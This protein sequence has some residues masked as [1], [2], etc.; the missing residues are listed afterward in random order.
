M[1]GPV[2][3]DLLTPR[4]SAAF[5]LARDLSERLDSGMQRHL[6]RLAIRAQPDLVITVDRR[7]RPDTVRALRATGARVVLWF[8]DAVANMWRHELFIA[9]YD[10]IYLKNSILVDQLAR[11][12]GLPVRYLPEAANEQW[13]R[14]V[15]P[16]GTASHIVVA[17]NLHPTR[18]V[19]LDRLLAAGIPLAIYGPALPSWINYPRVRAAHTGEFIVREEKARVFRAARGVLN[20]LHPAEFAGSN[21]RL[22]EAT[23]SGAATLTEWRDGMSDLFKPGVEVIPF[24]DFATLLDEC[25]RLLNDQS[26]GAAIGDAAAARSARDHTYSSRLTAIFEDLGLAGSGR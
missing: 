26:Y 23:G 15:G 16:Y 21:C 24:E 13:H 4:V 8:P 12:Y 22:F 2:R 17:G 10:R 7:L 18:A 6:S 9:G 14:P 19:L 11:V 25:R 1:A 3:R 20:N 5:S